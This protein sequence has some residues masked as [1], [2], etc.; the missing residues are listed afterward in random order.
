MPL[1]A[2]PVQAHRAGHHTLSILPQAPSRDVAHFLKKLLSDSFCVS[3]PAAEIHERLGSSCKTF[4]AGLKIATLKTKKEKPKQA[5]LAVGPMARQPQSTVRS[6]L[7]TKQT[8][9][10]SQDRAETAWHSLPLGK[11]APTG[12]PTQPASSRKPPPQQMPEPQ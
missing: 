4:L 3:F 11:P 10:M 9:V 1:P 8:P 2:R 7:Q 5:S 6:I 12:R